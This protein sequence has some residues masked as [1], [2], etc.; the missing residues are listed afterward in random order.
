MKA[1]ELLTDDIRNLGIDP[2]RVGWDV[3]T[4]QLTEVSY[5]KKTTLFQRGAIC[6]TVLFI[7]DG[8]VAVERLMQDGQAPI[9]RFFV[10][11]DICNDIVSAWR[12]EPS[13]DELFAVT[14]VSGL[15]IPYPFLLNQFLRSGD[16]FG[17]YLRIKVMESVLTD[18]EIM[19]RKTV[20]DTE[21]NYQFLEE[22]FPEVTAHAL[23]RQI[24]SY[25]GLTPEGLSRFLR[26]RR[27]KEQ[28]RSAEIL[29]TIG[30]RG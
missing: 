14:D 23:Q 13:T 27:E 19:A 10:A 18:I 28:A 20:S 1:I 9:N 29:E 5:K 26:K 30:A 7:T 25:L 6:N 8:I 16:V 21:L 2:D 3:I 12:N 17:E 11:T 4:P 24:A 22:R 15:L